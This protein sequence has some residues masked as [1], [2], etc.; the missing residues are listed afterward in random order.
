MATTPGVLGCQREQSGSCL[1]VCERPL[2]ARGIGPAKPACFQARIDET[3][4]GFDE[5]DRGDT[6]RALQ[7]KSEV[8]P[9]F[10]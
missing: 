8:P 1:R 2:Q 10:A 9:E 6:L 3:S 5:I 7:E 4:V